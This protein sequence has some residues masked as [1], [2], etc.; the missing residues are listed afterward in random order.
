MAIAKMKRLELVALQSD[1]ETLMEAL[2]RLGCVEI[3]EPEEQPELL[4]RQSSSLAERQSDLRRLTAALDALSRA[5][6]EKTPD[7]LNEPSA[8]P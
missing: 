3:R 4:H 6:P 8:F 2:L 1:R 7:Q 5:A